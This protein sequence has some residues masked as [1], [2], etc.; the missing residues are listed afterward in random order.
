VA[1]V[2]IAGVDNAAPCCRDGQCGSGRCRSGQM[3]V[4]NVL[5]TSRKSPT[6]YVRSTHMWYQLTVVGFGLRLNG[7]V[8]DKHDGDRFESDH[9]QSSRRRS[10][11][12]RPT[13][14][15]PEN[16]AE[17]Y[18]RRAHQKLHQS[19]WQQRVYTDAVL[20][21]PWVTAWASTLQRWMTFFEETYMVSC[22]H[23][24]FCESCAE[25]VHQRGD[26]CPLCRADITMILHL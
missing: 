26:R 14:P 20:G 16:K 21:R 7:L 19:L 18:E 6:I 10:S 11:S 3:P 23:Q 1:R 22:W 17:S 12:Q 2:D 25:T 13:Y 15:S 5:K 4:K 24:R 9:G 8:E